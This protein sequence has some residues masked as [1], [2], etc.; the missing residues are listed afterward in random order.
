MPSN[1]AGRTRSDDDEGT[2]RG[3]VPTDPDD[4]VA[5]PANGDLRELTRRDAGA[6]DPAD[7]ADPAVARRSNGRRVAYRWAHSMLVSLAHHVHSARSRSTRT[8]EHVGHSGAMR[9]SADTS[10]TSGCGRYSRAARRALARGCWSVIV[11]V[12]PGVGAGRPVGVCRAARAG[13]RPRAPAGAS[14]RRHRR[15]APGLTAAAR[16]VDDRATTTNRVALSARSPMPA[17]STTSPYRSPAARDATAPTLASPAAAT[18]RAAPA[19]S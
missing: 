14:A 8:R 7:P 10:R 5:A 3:Q 13:R 1:Y 17:S 2:Q 6:A 16:Q 19:V 18:S 15:Y 11:D 9:D 4:D 12:S